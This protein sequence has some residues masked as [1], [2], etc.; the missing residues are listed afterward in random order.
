[1]TRWELADWPRGLGEGPLR[2]LL[3]QLDSRARLRE[4]YRVAAGPL[5]D[6]RASPSGHGALCRGWDHPVIGRDQIPARL[7]APGGVADRAVECLDAP[8]D[9]RVGHEGCVSRGKIGRERLRELLP[10]E[11]QEPVD[12]RQDRGY[13]RAW[14]RVGD[15][16]ADRLTLVGC[17]GAADA[18]QRTADSLP[19]ERQ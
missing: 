12:G 17:E 5:G 15:Q 7:A 9:L 3:D 6:R 11:E 10:V 2:G 13:R 4:V 16:C 1:M 14:G 8:R 19:T 18:A